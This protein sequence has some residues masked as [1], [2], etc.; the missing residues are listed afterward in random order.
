MSSTEPGPAGPE[1]A[2]RGWLKPLAVVDDVIARFEAVVLALGVLMMAALSVANV[3]GRFVL[4]E[5]IAFTVEFNRF[6]IVLIT[7]VGIGYAARNGRHIR[8]SA[9]YDRLPDRG[10][11]AM[12]IIIAL[13]TAAAMFVLAWYAYVYV[14]SVAASGR[15]APSL[16][17]PVYLTLLWVPVGFVITGIQYVLTAVAN[18]TR[19]DVFI[20][21]SVVDSY[22]DTEASV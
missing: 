7:F 11:K 15:I 19:P 21:A 3:I 16:R 13:V 6:L 8:M 4:G 9:F 1:P 2:F 14:A 18:A 12:M 5:S 10:R 22:E 20:S 17:V